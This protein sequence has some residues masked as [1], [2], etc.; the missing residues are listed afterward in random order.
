MKAREV[1]VTV[2]PGGHQRG[3]YSASEAVQNDAVRKYLN[4]LYHRLTDQYEHDWQDTRTGAVLMDDM[5]E[6]AIDVDY[7][8]RLYPDDAD[9]DE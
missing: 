2:E 5:R 1:K 3:E 9:G 8:C 6:Y 4:G 7:D